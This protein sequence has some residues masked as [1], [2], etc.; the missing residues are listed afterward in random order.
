MRIQKIFIIIFS[1]IFFSVVLLAGNYNLSEYKAGDEV[2]YKNDAG[3]IIDPDWSKHSSI[4]VLDNGDILVLWGEGMKESRSNI[5][6]RILDHETKKWGPKKMAINRTFAAQFPHVVEDHNG[7]LHMSFQD[8]NSRLN[9]DIGY[10]YGVYNEDTKSFNWTKS[11]MFATIRKNSAWPKISMDHETEDLY[12]SWQHPKDPDALGKVYSNIVYRKYTKAK[13]EWSDLKNLSCQ[14]TT[15]SIHQATV[16][17]KNKLLGIFMD[18]TEACWSM[19]FNYSDYDKSEKGSFEVAY[20]VPGGDPSCYWPE[21]ELDSEGNVY[22]IFTRRDQTIRLIFLPYN[23]VGEGNF[24]KYSLLN[25]GNGYVTMIGLL[26]A[27]NDVAYAISV[28]GYEG[29]H[30]PYFI[31]FNVDTET[32]SIIKSNSYSVSNLTKEPRVPKLEVDNNGDVHCVWTGNE[33]SWYQKIGQ[34]A[35]GPKVTLTTEKEN[36]ITNTDVTFYGSSNSKIRNLRYYVRTAKYW[37][38]GNSNEGKDLTIQF[39]EEGYYKVHLYASD[40]NNL[41]GH[42]SI[43][44]HAIDS[45]YPPINAKVEANIIKGY[46]FRQG[47]N[48]LQ[49]EKN[50]ENI[51]KF[52]KLVN[53]S[54]YFRANEAD[55]WQFLTKVN[56]NESVNNYEY[57][58]TISGFRNQSDAEKYEYAVTVTAEHNEKEVESE[59]SVFERQ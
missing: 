9:R 24:W 38:E 54:L 33:Q 27:K 14:G 26:I 12:I 46:L 22:G 19:I 48:K 13:E 43:T 45:P 10:A 6:Y 8:G 30:Q 1:I 23:K 7:V 44:I 28:R 15:K 49:W 18:G 2:I 58:H 47:M 52:D 55:E 31:R 53:F 50:S 11:K 17:V 56:Y 40:D 20:Q 25:D 4:K 59:K 41:M 21:M 16:F 36:V 37:G 57:I 3:Q 5:V 42:T 39:P 34:P 29:G 51:D 35:G 32:G